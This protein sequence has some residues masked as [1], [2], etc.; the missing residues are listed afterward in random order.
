MNESISIV[1]QGLDK[2]FGK[3]K[4]LKNVDLSIYHGS[5]YCLIVVGMATISV[6]E[7]D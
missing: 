4:V 5:F 2:F 1:V 3:Q 6:R 7:K